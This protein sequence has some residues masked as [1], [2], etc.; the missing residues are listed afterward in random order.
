M[1]QESL[2]V[3]PVQVLL[4]RP[5]QLREELV[6]AHW[7]LRLVEVVVVDLLH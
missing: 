7:Y 4:R 1:A 5:P 2:R 6:V 3:Q